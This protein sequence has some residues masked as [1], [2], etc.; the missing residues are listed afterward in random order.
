M[1]SEVK[2][3]KVVTK[4]AKSNKDRDSDKFLARALVER[5]VLSIDEAK[6]LLESIEVF[7]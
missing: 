4:P 7:L 3:S 5:K 1:L 6:S 2:T